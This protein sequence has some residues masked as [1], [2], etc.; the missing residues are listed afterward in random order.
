MYESDVALIA[1]PVT[2]DPGPEYGSATRSW[3][4]I[5]ALDRGPSGRLWASW[6]TGGKGEDEDN[7]VVIVNSDDDGATWSKPQLVIDPPGQVRAFDQ[8]LWH[9]P[10]GRLWFLW[11]QSHYKFDGRA[12]VWFIRC[13]DPVS[14]DRAWTEPRRIADGVM[15]NK[16]TIL[17][18]GEWLFPVAM[19]HYAPE[20]PRDYP[21]PR[22]QGIAQCDVLCTEDC[23]KTFALRGGASLPPE[24]QGYEQMVVERKDGSLW[25]LMRARYG[26]GE[27][28]SFDAGRTW[29][30]GRKTDLGGPGSRFFIRRLNSGRLLLVNHHDFMS[31]E[32][33]P[34]FHKRNNL[35]AMLSDDEGR[36]WKGGLVLDDRFQTTYPDGCQADDGRVYIV[37]DRGRGTHKEILMCVFREEDVLAGKPVSPDARMGVLIDKAG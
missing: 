19:W 30:T 15:M 14:A 29:T 16:P 12:G 9:D 17:S 13:D 1:P 36:G 7:Y 4:G 28:E 23:G 33:Q 8:V 6:Y 24:D 20:P 3:Q 11:A 22:C 26:I 2:L 18:S 21:T 27:S 34:D 25:M 37:Y 10:L 35:T 31:R 5:P 32:G